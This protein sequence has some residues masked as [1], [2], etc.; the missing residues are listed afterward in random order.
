MAQIAKTG[1][2]KAPTTNTA[3]PAKPATD[4]VAELRRRAV[5][6]A[7]EATRGTAERV[8]NTARHG[9]ETFQRAAG[10][11]G[12][13]QR[14]LMQL[15]ATGTTELGRMFVELAS[16]QARQNFEM[17]K[18]LTG[19]V[20]WN[21]FAKAVDWDQVRQIQSAY[22]RASV[23][24]TARLT[25]RYLEVNQAVMTSAASATQ[26]QAKKAA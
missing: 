18:A 24:R 19:A 1:A 20:D 3:S 14:E 6:Q 15:S 22:L 5:D 8:E 13:A 12:E 26:R 23:D 21:R 2:E 11:A 10:A 25:R 4:N 16:E 7:A 9:A 17:L